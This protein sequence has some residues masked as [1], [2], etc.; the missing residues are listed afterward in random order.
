MKKIPFTINFNWANIILYSFFLCYGYYGAITFGISHNID[1]IHSLFPFLI[2]FLLII[3]IVEY[4]Y[5]IDDYR[6]AFM[7]VLYF[8]A[9]L[10]IY[11]IKLSE[12]MIELLRFF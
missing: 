9:W 12:L 5:F 4:F 11:A 8:L 7:K 1:F 2:Q 3:V 6:L 10:I